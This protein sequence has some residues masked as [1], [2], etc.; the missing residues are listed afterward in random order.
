MMGTIGVCTGMV[1]YLLSVVSSVGMGKAVGLGCGESGRKGG[2][3]C[4]S[5]CAPAWWRTC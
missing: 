3:M 1:A 2:Q 4:I 5:M